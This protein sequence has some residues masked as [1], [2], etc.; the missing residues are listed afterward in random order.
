MRPVYLFFFRERPPR[1]NDRVEQLLNAVLAVAKHFQA[2][3]VCQLA[4]ACGR[5]EGHAF[6]SP[7]RVG[8]LYCDALTADKVRHPCDRSWLPAEI[9][10]FKAMTVELGWKVVK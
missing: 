8:G 9:A 2:F 10:P 7:S 4:A 3:D 5:E 1:S 6:R